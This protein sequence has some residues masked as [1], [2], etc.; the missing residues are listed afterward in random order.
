MN[1]CRLLFA[2]K[3]LTL[4]NGASTRQASR[5]FIEILIQKQQ[6]LFITEVINLGIMH[7]HQGDHTKNSAPEISHRRSSLEPL[8]DQTPPAQETYPSLLNMPLSSL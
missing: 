6:R 2:L 5:L 4:R 8:I 3:T 1:P 7:S